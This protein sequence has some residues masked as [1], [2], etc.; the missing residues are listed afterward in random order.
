MTQK[1]KIDAILV[2]WHCRNMKFTWLFETF[3]IHVFLQ[4]RTVH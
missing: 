2:Y 1:K 4:L 3:N